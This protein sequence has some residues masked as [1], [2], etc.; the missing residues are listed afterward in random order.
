MIEDDC[1][2]NGIRVPN[3]RGEILSLV[4]AYCNKHGPVQNDS[5][6]NSR[7][8]ELKTYDADFVKVDQATL[9]HLI[10]AANFLNIKSLL[11]LTCQTVGD[12]MK[13]KTTEEIRKMFN[14]KNDLTPEEEEEGLIWKNLVVASTPEGEEEFRG[15]NQWSYEIW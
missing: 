10:L 11:D 5:E 1:A 15:E 12:M 14:I 8:D 3:V 4:V 13:G 6:D 9:F 7:S 2:D